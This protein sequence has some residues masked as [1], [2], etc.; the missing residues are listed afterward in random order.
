VIDEIAELLDGYARWVRDRS[1]L[2]ELGSQYV[3]LTTPYLDRNNDN[4]QLYIT[5]D[6]GGFTLTDAGET[7]AELRLSGC[8]L[9]TDK[10]RALLKNTLSGFGVQLHDDEI[11]VR[12]TADNFSLR[13]HSIVQAMLAVNDLFYLAGPTVASLFYE[14]VA[15]WLAESEVRFTPN[16]R[17]TGKSGFDYHYDF[18]IPA[19][20]QHPERLVNA[21]ARPSRNAA[22]ALILSWIDTRDTRAT[23]SQCYGILND[24]DQRVSGAVIEALRSYGIRPVKWTERNTAISELLN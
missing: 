12:A 7:I 1:I 15:R 16:V 18:A 20:G 11:R 3:E 6:D 22:S 9:D 10:R 21:I 14:D 24:A 23:G 17:F 13:K 8:E 5:R 19:S 2:R 4:L